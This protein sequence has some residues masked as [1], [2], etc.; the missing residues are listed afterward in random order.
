MRTN[1]FITYRLRSLAAGAV[2]ELAPQAVAAG[3]QLELAEG[4]EVEISGIP[5]LL[6][7]LLRNLID[8]AIRYSP[9]NT[10]VRV[11]VAHEDRA[12]RLTVSDQGPGIPESE[13]PKIRDRFY[14]LLGT[15]QE[16]TGLGLSI[17]QR[18]AEIHGTT[19][20]LGPGDGGKG[21]RATVSF[22]VARA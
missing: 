21:L 16:G 2:A 5:A 12:A 4:H 1:R 17:V 18:I 14:R 10:T 3:V 22:P 8:N 6:Q 11:R 9:A 19:L 15:G 13:L 20:D 7:A